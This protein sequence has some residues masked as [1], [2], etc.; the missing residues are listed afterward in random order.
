MKLFEGETNTRLL[1]LL[2][3]SASMDAFGGTTAGGAPSKLRYAAFVAAAL[4]F[5]AVRQHDAVGLLIF[6]QA[7][8]SYLPP[9]AGKGNAQ[10]IY[11]ALDDL[12]PEGGSD[13][14][15]A[16]THAASR[17]PKRGVI[18]AISDFYCDAEDFSRA[19]GILG[20]RGHDL[21]M[22]H[23]LD[24]DETRPHRSRRAPAGRVFGGNMTL[25]DAET[26]RVIEVDANDLRAGY[27]ARLAAHESALRQAAGA[28]GADYVRLNADEPLERAL[29]GYLRF[30]ARRP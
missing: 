8:R 7:V 14:T 5:I 11:H 30:R 23:L 17:F 18:A 6:D 10:A 25:R 24:A 28:A 20:A 12:H 4:T 9:R 19:L 26:G 1:V 13:W 21:V 2:D 15:E 16:F 27:P 3:A 22:F 29:T